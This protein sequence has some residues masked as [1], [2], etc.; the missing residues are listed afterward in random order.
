MDPAISTAL[1]IYGLAAGI[2]AFVALMIKIIYWSVRL[3]QR[4]KRE[5]S[6]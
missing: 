5:E 1:L 2:S 3:T 4:S 6:Q